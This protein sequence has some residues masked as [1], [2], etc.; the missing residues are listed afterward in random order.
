MALSAPIPWN[1]SNKTAVPHARAASTRT[2]QRLGAQES[3]PHADEMDHL[4]AGGPQPLLHGWS[5]NDL[6]TA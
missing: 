2:I 6:L 4:S 3:I 5:L 1:M